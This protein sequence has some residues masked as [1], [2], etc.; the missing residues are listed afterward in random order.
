ME[1]QIFDSNFKLEKTWNFKT[2]C[3]RDVSQ[4]LNENEQK[5]SIKEELKKKSSL[6][7]V[8]Q[9]ERVLEIV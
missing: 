5:N 6:L 2:C 7:S 1:F 9:P 3:P 8:E 4:I